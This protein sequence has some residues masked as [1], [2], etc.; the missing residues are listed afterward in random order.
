MKEFRVPFEQTNIVLIDEA[1]IDEAQ[2]SVSA[3]EHCCKDASMTF[4][5]FLD[6]LTGCDPMTTEY[7]MCRP[8]KCPRCLG[9]ITEKTRILY[10]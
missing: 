2:L 10:R 7:L 6:A 8:A 1:I 4:D 3:C 5:F 9:S